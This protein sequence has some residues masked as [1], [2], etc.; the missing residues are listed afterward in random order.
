MHELA[1]CT[2]I[3]ML[4]PLT[5]DERRRLVDSLETLYRALGESTA[6][7]HLG[8]RGSEANIDRGSKETA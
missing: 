7:C 8:R 3:E 2:V 5:A 6:I 1:V 4:S